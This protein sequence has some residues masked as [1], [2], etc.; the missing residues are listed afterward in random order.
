MT[1]QEVRIDSRFRV[2]HLVVHRI[3]LVSIDLV[4]VVGSI[5]QFVRV[6]LRVREIWLGL[7]DIVAHQVD[8]AEQ[9][10]QRGY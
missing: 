5:V 3:I 10:G 8:R 1:G 4:K 9:R 6:V 2:I 7:D